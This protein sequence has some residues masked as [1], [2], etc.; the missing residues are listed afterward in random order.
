MK[1]MGLKHIIKSKLVRV[2]FNG[3]EILKLNM[4]KS[5][6]RWELF[7]LYTSVSHVEKNKATVLLSFACFIQFFTL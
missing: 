5:V 3:V 2:L 1:S 6:N 4:P 7:P